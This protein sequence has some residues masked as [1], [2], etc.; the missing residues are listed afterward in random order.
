[1]SFNLSCTRG[2]NYLL[3]LLGQNG[4]VSVRNGSTLAGFTDTANDFFAAER[5]GYTT[6]LYYSQ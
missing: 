5:F 6:S 1:M 2:T 4:Q 3:N